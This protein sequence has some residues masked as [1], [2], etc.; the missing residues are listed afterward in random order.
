[1][2]PQTMVVLVFI[3][4]ICW[5]L[6]ARMRRMVG[7]QKSSPA[8]QWLAVILWPLLIGLMALGVAHNAAVLAW[9]GGGIV[10]GVALGVVGNRLTRFEQMA[11]GLYYTPNAHI[12]IALSLL[13]VARIAYRVVTAGFPDLAGNAPP[14]AAMSPM[15]LCLFGVLAGYY[16]SYAC[17]LILWRRRTTRGV[18]SVDDAAVAEGRSA[19]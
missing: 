5:R 19:S 15:T 11:D 18:Q 10:V 9:L 14:A 12:G 1:M 17:G 4:L 6:Y 7:R 2:A 16:V 13:L 8:R 3:P